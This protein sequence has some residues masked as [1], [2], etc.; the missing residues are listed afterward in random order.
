MYEFHRGKPWTHEVLVAPFDV[1]IYKYESVLEMERDSALKSFVPFYRLDTLVVEKKMELYDLFFERE[2][3]KYVK[4]ISSEKS[5]YSSEK[6]LNKIR[7]SYYDDIKALIVT[8]YIQGIVSDAPHFES[9]KNTQES[10]NIIIGQVGEE[11]NKNSVFTQI[12]AYQF[13]R[14][15]LS[16]ISEKTQPKVPNDKRFLEDS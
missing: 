9:I 15:Q 8:L 3:G 13:I 5:L 10:V 16:I 2:W 11:K 7:N 4:R 6:E 14:E 12:T 1:P